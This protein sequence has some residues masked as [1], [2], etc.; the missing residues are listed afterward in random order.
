MY[1]EGQRELRASLYVIDSIVDNTLDHI[2]RSI[3]QSVEELYHLEEYL[4][5]EIAHF[6]NSLMSLPAI[7][8]D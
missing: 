1:N 4:P 5:R 6:L 7:E 8:E 2:D 3:Y